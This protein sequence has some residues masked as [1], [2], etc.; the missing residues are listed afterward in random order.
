M[1]DLAL[2]V[3][4]L[5]F[6]GGMVAHGLA[7]LGPGMAEFS[8]TVAELGFPLPHALAWAAALA[9]I[10]GGFLLLVGLFTR[11]AA[12]LPTAV[13]LVAIFRVHWGTPW[14]EWEKAALYLAAV[15]ALAL[16]GPGRLSLDRLLF[17]DR[18]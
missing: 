13:M 17:R 18:P 4:R 15:L 2:L 10:L 14:P 6:G 16:A 5:T 12:A 9:E 11:Y 8:R 3:L 1:T 7:K